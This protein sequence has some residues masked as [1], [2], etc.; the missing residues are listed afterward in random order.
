M[1]LCRVAPLGL[2]PPPCSLARAP[3]ALPRALCFRSTPVRT[4]KRRLTAMRPPA[5]GGEEAG[6]SGA[7]AA[8]AEEDAE[9]QAIRAAAALAAD[10]FLR[11][12]ERLGGASRVAATVPSVH[13]T[14]QAQARE[15]CFLPNLGGCRGASP[16]SLARHIRPSRRTKSQW[17]WAQDPPS[18]RCCRR[19]RR[20]RCAAGAP[21][22]V[23]CME[24][25]Q[26]PPSSP[27]RRGPA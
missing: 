25:G 10:T 23:C 15:R 19:S 6:G 21:L 17:V 14:T 13:C 1:S 3:A 20:G 26:H 24:V 4:L 5:A 27:G 8:G 7:A 16:P 22:L 9:Q 11:V 12:C 2:A 18:M